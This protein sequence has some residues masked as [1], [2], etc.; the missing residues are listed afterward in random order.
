MARNIDPINIKITAQNDD[1]LFKLNKSGERIKKM[2]QKA[3][4]DLKKTSKGFNQA[5]EASQKM[6]AGFKRAA[7]SAAI[8]TGPLNGISGRLSFIASGLSSMGIAAVG[9]S[10]SFAALGTM[11]VKGVMAAAQIESE[12]GKVSAVLSATGNAAGLTATQ[13]DELANSVARGSLATVADIRK[14]STAL[15]TFKTVT[16]DTFERTIA[17]S[18]D[19]ATVLGGDAKSAAL[20]LGKALEDPIVGLTAL[21]RSGVSFTETEKEKISLMVKSGSLLE[22]QGLILDKVSQQVGGA[23]AGANVGLVGATDSLNQSWENMLINIGQ[24]SA[25]TGP[26]AAVI[27][28]LDA[29]FRRLSGTVGLTLPEKLSFLESKMAN[30]INVQ[31]MLMESSGAGF[32][33]ANIKIYTDKIMVL[34]NEIAN[35]QQ[36]QLDNADAAQKAA[37]DVQTA[38]DAARQKRIQGIIETE[39][40]EL[41][42]VKLKTKEITGNQVDAESARLKLAKDKAKEKAQVWISEGVDEITANE[43]LQQKLAALDAQSIARTENLTKNQLALQQDKLDRQEI[44]ELTSEGK[45]VDAANRKLEVTKRMLEDE[46]QTL[47]DRGVRGEEVEEI[48]RQRRIQAEAETAAVIAKFQADAAPSIDLP[49]V[50]EGDESDFNPYGMF[51]GDAS[52]TALDIWTTF[53]NEKSLISA[54]FAQSDIDAERETQQQIM[55]IKLQYRNDL[56]ALNLE[57]EELAKEA[58]TTQQKEELKTE[59]DNDVAKLKNTRD[60]GIKKANFDGKMKK[61]EATRTK[62]FMKAGFNELVKNNKAAFRIK[63]AYDIA[64]AVQNTYGAA[65]GAYKAMVGIPIVG[66]SLAVAAAAAAVSFGAMQVKSIASAKPGGS[67]SVGGGSA[68]S[69]PSIPSP[70]APAFDDPEETAFEPVAREVNLFVDG[71]IDPSGTR[72]ILE[73]VN[74]QLGDGVNLNVEFGT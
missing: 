49:P 58:K 11:M 42:A 6:G 38:E 13:I 25:A 61:D 57:Y 51:N 27:G 45:F 21:K 54:A 66:P 24:T 47:H 74:E 12:M 59:F 26:V 29:H 68:P 73:A 46:L 35:L 9:A 5:G 72:R 20:Q 18:Q 36:Q 28:A 7:N 64:E 15:L 3:D 43:M 69:A 50:P 53:L 62:N 16:G 48:F 37:T 63:Q 44:A 1:L 19:L 60:L 39:Q 41:D 30:L 17:L 71:S 33:D 4:K 14:A 2:S 32:D 22:A 40:L 8:L 31:Q 52:Q 23:A 34:Q 65:I 70:A 10:A 67:A 56:N 55:D